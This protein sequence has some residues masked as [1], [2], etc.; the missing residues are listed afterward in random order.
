MAGEGTWGSGA[1]APLVVGT[2]APGMK[3]AMGTVSVTVSQTV[4]VAGLMDSVI[5]VVATT[6]EANQGAG[7]NG[8]LT[9]TVSGTTVTILG[10]DDTGAAASVASVVSY[11]IFG[12]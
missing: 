12:K 10:W 6:L 2:N 7:D 9:Y 1:A 4:S 5:G 8:Y 3:M 11:I